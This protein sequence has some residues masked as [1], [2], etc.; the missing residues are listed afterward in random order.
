MPKNHSGGPGTYSQRGVRC[1][2]DA[3]MGG[4]VSPGS[5]GGI[6]GRNKAPFDKPQSM[7]NGGIPTKFF[8]G[9]SAK[10]A[11]TSNAGMSEPFAVATQNV[12]TRRFKNPK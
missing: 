12:G 1:T 2:M 5:G 4:N 9:M 3:P 11:K 8:D 10:P 7:G 6:Q